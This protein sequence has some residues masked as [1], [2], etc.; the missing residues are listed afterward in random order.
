M[1]HAFCI[2]KISGRADNGVLRQLAQIHK[3]EIDGGSLAKLGTR[4]LTRLYRALSSSPHSF[5]IVARQEEYVAGF[6]C[7]AIDARSVYRRFM[8]RRGLFTLPIL[9]PQLVSPG[10][11]QRVLETLLYPSKKEHQNLPRPEIL[12]FCVTQRW[13]RRG[14]GRKLFGA[15]VGEFRERDVPRIKIVTGD[16]QTKAQMFYESLHATK[17]AEIE[18]HDGTTSLVYTYD[19]PDSE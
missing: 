9:L 6:I 14:L 11:L 8:L 13:Q 10:R 16:K 19:I 1:E 15:L 12:S 18:I 4:F 17:A 7:G 2:E 3:E 5:V